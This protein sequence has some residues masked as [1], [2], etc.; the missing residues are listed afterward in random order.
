[1]KTTTTLLIV[2]F[3]FTFLQAQE[4]RELQ[5]EITD[6]TV[7]GMGAQIH[8]I[9]NVDVPEGKTKIKITG[10]TPDLDPKSIQVKAND[11]VTILSVSH[12]WNTSSAANS[13]KALDS[14]NQIFI[15]LDKVAGQL[16]MR[17]GI[18]DQ[19]LQLLTQNGNLRSETSGVT[20]AQ[21]QS[22]L[23][24]FEAT[25][26]SANQEKIKIAYQLDSL[27]KLKV[28][29]TRQIGAIRGTP[30]VSKSEIEILIITDH[31]TNA[32]IEVSY[33]VRN[34]GWIP[35]YDIRAKDVSQPIVVMYKAEVHQQTG[36]VWKNVKLSLSNA[37]P[38]ARQTAPELQTWKL[39]T[40]ANT[41]FRRIGPA[42][43]AYGTNMVTGRVLDEET[44]E[45]LIFANVT[46][47][48]H[49]LGTQ[50]DLDGNFSIMLPQGS[51]SL[52][53]S[54]TGFE[55]KNVPVTQQHLDIYLKVGMMLETAVVAGSRSNTF[56][57][58]LNGGR[59]S[60]MPKAPEQLTVIIENQVSVEFELKNR[61]TILSDGKNSSL[62]V[63]AYEVPAEYH[64][65]TAPKADP[66][67]YLIATLTNWE[68]YHLIEG[69]A[70]LYFKNTY[71]GKTILDPLNLSDTL[72]IS[73]GRDPEILVERIKE[74][75]FTKKTFL[76][77]NT[78]IE[79]N[80][81]LTFRNKKQY[82]IRIQ[83]FDQ[84]PV[85]V[86]DAVDVTVTGLTGGIQDEPSGIIKWDFSIDPTSNKE[87]RMSYAVKYPSKERVVLE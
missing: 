73:L 34:A 43:L 16:K 46:V 67:A 5:T 87:L 42:E 11:E 47:S 58:S 71:I 86:N 10:L 30:L 32:Q 13:T 17:Q 22:A 25:W 62:E 7:F 27:E 80:F 19:K 78:I 33:I 9:G 8:R 14:L 29:T 65:E 74:D 6:V 64:Y 36:E 53:V 38:Y 12:E 28:S 48:G 66:G 39:T 20:A 23:T 82:P 69:Q 26:M 1:M 54:Y 57:Y 49:S 45:P 55:T 3:I 85:S 75:E 72:E 60:S 77:T 15:R 37:S 50:T 52:I 61:T 44:G 83:V 21:L 70:N 84:V 81:R 40:L 56:N 59:V 35:K 31:S 18:L 2:Q 68:K 79:K 4:S 24:L 41:T 76:G 51:N 63:Q